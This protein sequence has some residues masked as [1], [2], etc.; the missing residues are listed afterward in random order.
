MNAPH[1]PVVEVM[2]SALD[3]L[4]QGEIMQARSNKVLLKFNLMLY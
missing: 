4:V 1:A 2:A 3:S